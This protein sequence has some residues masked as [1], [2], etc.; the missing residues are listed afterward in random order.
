DRDGQQI[1]SICEIC[2]I[3]GSHST[4]LGWCAYYSSRVVAPVPFFLVE[5]APF[6]KV[7]H[8]CRPRIADRRMTMSQRMEQSGQPAKSDSVETT[9][10]SQTYAIIGAGMEVHRVLGCGFLEP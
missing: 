5:P 3:C 9:R 7:I 6:F 1:C 8:Y 4:Q 10:D 2:V